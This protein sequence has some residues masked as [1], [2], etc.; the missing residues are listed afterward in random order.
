MLLAPLLVNAGSEDTLPAPD[1]PPANLDSKILPDNPAAAAATPKAI[2]DELK[3]K[4]DEVQAL[5]ERM[6]SGAK[7]S[8]LPAGIKPEELTEQRRLIESLVFF[9][10][11]GL[12]SLDATQDE[13]DKLKLTETQARAWTAF[14]DP[15]P[16]SMLM[17]YGLEEEADALRGKQAVLESS[18]V[19]WQGD[20]AIPQA[21]VSR[22]QADARLSGDAADRA[23]SPAEGAAAA[24]RR[25][26]AQW[27]V[28]A[29]ERNVWFKGIQAGLVNAKLA[30][31]RAEAAWLGKKIDVARRGAVLSLADMD[32]VREGL[33]AAARNLEQEQQKAVAENARWIKERDLAMRTLAAARAEPRP[34]GADNAAPA[35][36]ETLAARLRTADAWVEATRQQNETL[37]TLAVFHARIGEF[38]NYQYT[39]LNSRDQPSRQTA[40]QQLQR[41]FARLQQWEA[42][43]QDNL[44]LAVSEENNQQANLDGIGVDA[45]TR[46]YEAQTLEALRLKRQTAER[47][48]LLAD[49]TEHLLG[50]WLEDCR[51]TFADRPV[52]DRVKDG[53]LD[54]ANGAAQ[55]FRFELFT[56]DDEVDLEGKKTSIVRGVTLGTL[57]T[58][59]AVFVAGFWLAK[60]L[61]RRFQRM[62]VGQFA[63]GVAQSNVLRRWALMGL[64]LVLLVIVLTLARIPLTVFAFMGGALVIGVGFG[65][66]TLLKNLISGLMLLVEQKIKVGDIVEVDGIVGTITEIDIRSST[67]RGADGVETIIPNSTFLENKVANW[68][69]TSSTI[70]R[71]VRVKVAYGSPSRDVIR[72]CWI[73][74]TATARCWTS[75]NRMCGWRRWPTTRWC[76]VCISGWRW[77]LRPVRCK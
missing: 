56:V 10:Q 69:Y 58:A 16:Y 3:Q 21:E 17:L 34:G 51:E 60:W 48:R 37:G 53:L 41:D 57:L 1:A 44:G 33:K 30:G 42:Y 31:V 52:M 47:I 67:V 77:G 75:L 28:R 23:D 66:Q 35:P 4:L 74:P 2:R 63:M 71:S 24:W 11:E 72:L 73:A 6:D 32:K 65:T 13:Q 54:A 43:T 5:R 68:T 45:P 14:P 50:H 38:W 70:R 59:C 22:A 19:G 46:R 18:L 36:G 76:S 64:S 39:L 15:P 55:L 27:R 26:F 62:L 40:F 49:R 9:Y 8:P 20:S 61:S 25:D 29:A 7:G 12:N